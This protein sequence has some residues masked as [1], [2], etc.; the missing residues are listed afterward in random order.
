MPNRIRV[1]LIGLL[2]AALPAS[3]ITA[4]SAEYINSYTWPAPTPRTGGFSALEV[5]GD[6]QEFMAISDLGLIATGQLHR[7]DGLISGIAATRSKLK[8][9]DNGKL[10]PF[11]SD[12]EGL[13][14]RADGR[15]YV[16]FE[17]Y[18]RIWT[19]NS[20]D[21]QAAWIPRHPEFGNMDVN[22]G[23]EALAIGP[24]GALY[25]MAEGSSNLT[26]PFTVYRHRNG[27]WTTPFSI[28]R[29]GTFLPVGADF[30]PDGRLYLLERKLRSVF[31][32]ETRVRRFA[33]SGDT[34]S[35]EVTL[36]TTP[37]GTHDNLEGLSVWRDAQGD[38]RLT[39]V[40][41]NNLNALQRTE[42]VE[43]RIKE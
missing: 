43:Y 23:M 41:D 22:G 28:P 29:I 16:S 1:A 15:I 18:H 26:T 42:F 20:P 7:K 30:G 21:G 11:N 9:T 6:G 33:I 37:A 10:S 17:R 4:Q 14:I 2:L 39:M 38:I 36:L 24:G 19:Y 31:G 8:N 35:D 32:F 25:T 40:S 27:T 3:T 12:A 34:I 5:S 13:A